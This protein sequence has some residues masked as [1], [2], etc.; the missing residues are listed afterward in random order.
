MAAKMRIPIGGE[1]GFIDLWTTV[2]LTHLRLVELCAGSTVV[3][4]PE[5]GNIAAC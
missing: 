3:L 5:C 2:D 4:V 1:N